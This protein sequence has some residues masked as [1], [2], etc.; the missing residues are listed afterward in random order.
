M[1]IGNNYHDNCDFGKEGTSGK[2]EDI[3]VLELVWK[4][5]LFGDP[6]LIQINHSK[7]LII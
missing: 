6:I 3:L 4:V 1:E 2:K 7:L 5:V